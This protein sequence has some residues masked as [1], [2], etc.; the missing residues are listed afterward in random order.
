MLS[1]KTVESDTLE[2]L[3]GLMA[4]PLLSEMRLGGGTALALQYGHRN[5]IDLDF[6]GK[7]PEDKDEEFREMLRR[8]GN[9]VIL[10]EIR[11][12]KCYLINEIKVDFVNYKYLWIDDAICDDGLRLAS[13]KDIAAMKINAVEGRGTKKDFVDIYFLLEKYSLTEILAFYELK[14]PEH[15]QF[16]ALI[17]L[18]YF[19]DAEQQPMPKMFMTAEWED[20]KDAILQEITKLSS[21]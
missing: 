2:L 11:T 16:R 7:L 1:Y 18:S 6:F 9:V 20:I 14:Y 19:E 13:P 5:S 8:Y 4:E 15:S 17:S 10:K 3:R 12:I 21:L